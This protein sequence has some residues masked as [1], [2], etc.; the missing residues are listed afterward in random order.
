MS[1]ALGTKAEILSSVRDEPISGVV[2]DLIF[3]SVQE[4][5]SGMSELV[6]GILHRFRNDR[7]AVRSS[8]LSEDK[9]GKSLAGHFHTRLNIPCQKDSIVEAVEAVIESYDSNLDNQVLIQKMVIGVTFSGVIITHELHSGIPYYVINYVEDSSRTDLITSGEGE[10]T[11]EY[12]HRNT[13]ISKI[14]PPGFR[15]VIKVTRELEQLFQYQTLDIEFAEDA[16]GTLHILQIRKLDFNWKS[17]AELTNRV[18]CL[19]D[20]VISFVEEQNKPKES[21]AGESTVWSQMS[22]WNP[23]ELIGQHPTPLAVSLF[24]NLITDT[25]WREARQFIG[26]RAVPGKKLLKMLAGRP[27]IDVRNSFN[28]WLPSDL[29]TGTENRIVDAWLEYFREN[30]HLHDKVEFE[31]A[32]TV[33]DFDFEEVFNRR[34]PGI[35]TDQE[36]EA[37]QSRLADL[38][39]ACVL[40]DRQN[41]FQIAIERIRH[42]ERL[43]SR[44]FARFG[45]DP[46]AHTVQLLNECRDFGTFP[47]SIIARHAFI[48]ET[49]LRS[50]VRKEAITDERLNQF[51]SSAQTILTELRRELIAATRC[52]SRRK[53][54]LRRF[55]HLRP[56]SFDIESPRYDRRRSLFQHSPSQDFEEPSSGGRFVLGRGETS[57]LNKLLNGA[58]FDIKAQELFHLANRAVTEREYAKFIFSR[59][60][61]SILESIALWGNRFGL[62]RSELSYLTL[63]NILAASTS[64]TNESPAPRLR[65]WSESAHQI[66]QDSRRLPL[67]QVIRDAGDLM[68]VVHGF[69]A[70]NFVTT[71]TTKGRSVLLCARDSNEVEIRE[72]IVCIESADPGFDWIFAR[73]PSGLV[74]QFG[75]ANSHM[76]IR[77]A[78]VNIPAAI[79]V[80]ERLFDILKRAPQIHL[81]CSDK[82]VRP[83]YGETNRSYDARS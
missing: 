45:Q 54:F 74:T 8:T 18:Q 19:L 25:V 46:I 52:K 38:T 4:W 64:G 14:R 7:L 9:S 63:S 33:I 20:E 5:Y 70:P 6:G 13:P 23:A 24:E 44:G 42:L 69:G 17:R 40:P 56:S 76:A 61:S 41:S 65:E 2:P 15:Q 79:G 21:I 78:E 53:D 80:G 62:N 66:I 73:R 36:F 12:V 34:F 77:C 43:Q 68:I 26:Y 48:F 58:G 31:I 30:P 50:A 47:F 60:L 75:G 32:Q 51:H 29:P 82:V 37:Y 28:S 57:D 11:T 49:I 27:F 39:M 81:S 22:D 55:G 1:R 16:N 35:L 67:N 72:K 83:I 10:H 3:F 71:L 59:H